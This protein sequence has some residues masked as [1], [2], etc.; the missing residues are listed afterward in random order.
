MNVGK[1]GRGIP[2]RCATGFSLTQKLL[3]YRTRNYSVLGN[4]VPSISAPVAPISGA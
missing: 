4:N 3:E 1:K 2:Q